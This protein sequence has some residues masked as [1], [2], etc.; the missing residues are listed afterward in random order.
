M[1]EAAYA[2]FRAAERKLSIDNLSPERGLRRL[3]EFTFDYCAENPEFIALLNNANLLSRPARALLQVRAL[4]PP[5]I[6]S[7][8]R[9]LARGRTAG[10]FRN[11]VDPLRL[12]ISIA[13]LGYFYSRTFTRCPPPST[14]TSRPRRSGACNAA[15]SST[16]CCSRSGLTG[17]VPR[18]ENNRSV[19]YGLAMALHRSQ[20]PPNPWPSS[21]AARSFRHTRLH[22]T[23][24]ASS[25]AGASV[26]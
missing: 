22:S 5:L 4:Y 3:I 2:A 16:S 26:H 20:I 15:T 17:A 25:T 18:R 14:A 7:I 13:A 24:S 23:R 1:L 8:R 19:T 10:T 9:L 21:V 11:G 12:Y 6:D